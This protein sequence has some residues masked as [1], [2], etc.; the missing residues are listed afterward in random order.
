MKS[1]Y[2]FIQPQGLNSPDA[3]Y[4]VVWVGSS[5]RELA[6]K[7]LVEEYAKDTGCY[8][9][10]WTC[11]VDSHI[12]KANARFRGNEDAIGYVF[13]SI[14]ITI[15][16]LSNLIVDDS[17]GALEKAYVMSQSEK[18][19]RFHNTLPY[20]QQLNNSRVSQHVSPSLRQY[21]SLAKKSQRVQAVACFVGI[22]MII[23][24]DA[25]VSHIGNSFFSDCF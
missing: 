11:L 24:M 16:D 18:W 1:K 5:L 9:R 12:E 19:A 10:K 25:L 6:I 17:F 15:K 14:E 4:Y 13:R 8:F 21:L 22:L 23:A 3:F 20:I 2:C 7:S